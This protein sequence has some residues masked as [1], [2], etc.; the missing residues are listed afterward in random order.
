MYKLKGICNDYQTPSFD[1]NYV[2][3]EANMMFRGISGSSI[4][5]LNTSDQRWELFFNNKQVA[6]VVHY[7][8]SGIFPFGKN[9]WS[10]MLDCDGGLEQAVVK[11]LKF[12]RV[13]EENLCRRMTVIEYT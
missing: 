9:Q 7:H 13:N 12:T 2:Y 10:L 1:I 6:R 8:N 4:M 11:S 3:D 5:T